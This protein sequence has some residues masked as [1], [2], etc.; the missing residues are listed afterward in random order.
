MG[1]VNILGQKSEGFG[2][3]MH[4]TSPDYAQ[5]ERRVR[6]DLDVGIGEIVVRRLGQTPSS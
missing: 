3:E 5:A 4:V 2:R 6:L 1:A